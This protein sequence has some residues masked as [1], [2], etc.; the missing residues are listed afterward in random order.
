MGILAGQ[1]RSI[2]LFLRQSFQRMGHPPQRRDGLVR[3]HSP[4]FPSQ[5][6]IISRP[7][8]HLLSQRRQSCPILLH[9]HYVRNHT[10]SARTTSTRPAL[11]AGGL[12]LVLQYCRALLFAATGGLPLLPD[13]CTRHA[14]YNELGE[15]DVWSDFHLRYDLLCRLWTVYLHCSG[16]VGPQG[17]GALYGDVRG[18]I[19]GST[20]DNFKMPNMSCLLSLLSA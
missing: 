4:A 6:R 1:R 11:V 14:S 5:H 19:R 18:V 9:R 15:H 7:P 2:L 3:H 10:P 16:I 13:C 8:G 20:S 17:Y 12:R